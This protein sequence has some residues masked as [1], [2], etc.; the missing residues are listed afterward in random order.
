MGRLG[1]GRFFK[2]A[3]ACC[4]ASWRTSG[5]SKC[6]EWI[7]KIFKIWIVFR[8]EVFNGVLENYWKLQFLDLQS[9]SYQEHWIHYLLGMKFTESWWYCHPVTFQNCSNFPKFCRLRGRNDGEKFTT[10]VSPFMTTSRRSCDRWKWSCSYT[11]TKCT[12]KAKK[13]R[14]KQIKKN[15]SELIENTPRNHERIEDRR[16]SLHSHCILSVFYAQQKTQTI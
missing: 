10:S 5:D 3:S 8:F 6:N 11:H 9:T 1:L 7:C 4:T 13:K 14:K 2:A 12:K 15:V 16:W